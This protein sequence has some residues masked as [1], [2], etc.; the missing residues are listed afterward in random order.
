MCCVSWDI[1][2]YNGKPKETK[3][4]EELK[5]SQSQNR[6]NSQDKYP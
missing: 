1:K 3:L 6:R 2:N 5:K 4:S